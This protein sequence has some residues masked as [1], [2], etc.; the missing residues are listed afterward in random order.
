MNLPLV[1]DVAIG[2]IF[3]YLILSLLA[4]EIQEI[5]TT[6]LQWRAVHL[7]KSIENLLI[8]EEGTPEETKK[9]KQIVE[10]LYNNPLIENINQQSKEG[11]EA[12]LRQMTWQMSKIFHLFQKQDKS[13]FGTNQRTNKEKQS[14]PSYIPA[15][16]FATT[17]LERLNIT[18]LSQDLSALNLIRLKEEEIKLQ[19]KKIIIDENLEISQET[20]QNLEINLNKLGKR[21]DR[22]TNNYKLQKASLMN[23]LKWMENEIKGFTDNSIAYFSEQE[24]SSK[25]YFQDEMNSL[26]EELFIDIDALEKRLKAGLSEVLYELESLKMGG[27]LYKQMQDG[28]TDETSELHQAYAELQQNLENSIGRLPVSVRDSLSALG[29][30]AQINAGKVE[31]ELKQFQK[32]VETWFDRS[33]DRASG[34]YK[35]NAKGV[36]FLIGLFLAFAANADT[37]HIIDRLSKDTAVRTAITRYAGSAVSNCQQSEL[38]CIR[39]QVNQNIESLPIGWSL[40]KSPQQDV[41]NKNWLFPTLKRI[42]GW[43]LSGFAISMGAP[44]W[45]ELLGKFINVRN[46]GPK[47]SSS[48]ED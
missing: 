17:L 15:E 35:R 22:I 39:D 44:F 5:I 4:A 33:M 46:T 30:R 31:Q 36:A 1:L 2:L 32:E 14:A 38:E 18:K 40:E 34:V 45:F 23:S 13:I 41:E 29:R 42:L 47:P 7:K 48:T 21:L 26:K 12:L 27:R 16:T 37:L 19:I 11:I 3:I 24:T 43:I 9:V 6:L 8:G 20:R 25:E 10:D 28:L